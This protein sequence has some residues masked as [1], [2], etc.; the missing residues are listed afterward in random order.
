MKLSNNKKDLDQEWKCLLSV[1]SNLNWDGR[2]IAKKRIKTIRL[3][4]KKINK[5]G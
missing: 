4:L 2:N 3:K 5:N 1:Y